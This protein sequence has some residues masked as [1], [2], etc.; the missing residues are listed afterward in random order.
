VIGN[1]KRMS[2]EANPE[3]HQIK[4]RHP[5]FKDNAERAQHYL[6]QK[7]NWYYR[8]RDRAKAKILENYEKRMQEKIA[9]A[10]AEGRE[11]PKRR[12]KRAVSQQEKNEENK[13][14]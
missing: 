9:Q 10:I 6:E 12:K 1:K 2:E 14:S 4:K 13:T 7:R 3:A 8:H 5:R 11:P